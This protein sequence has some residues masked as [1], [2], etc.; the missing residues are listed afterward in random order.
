MTNGKFDDL[1]RHDH[2]RLT[3]TVDLQE[4]RQSHL[5]FLSDACKGIIFNDRVGSAR[6]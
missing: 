3:K 6:A 2:A 1:S 5:R 4:R